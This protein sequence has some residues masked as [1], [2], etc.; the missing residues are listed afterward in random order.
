MPPLK[1]VMSRDEIPYTTIKELGRG[2]FGKVLEVQ[3]EYGRRFALKF[4]RTKQSNHHHRLKDLEEEIRN[5]QT[6]QNH[7]HFVRVRDAY[8]ANNEVGFI[9][10]PVAD[11][12][13]LESCIETFLDNQVA[14]STLVTVF[15][16]AFGC[17]VSGL[18]FMH[19]NRIRHKDIKPANILIHQGRVLCESKLMILVVPCILTPYC[20][21]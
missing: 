19:E 14:A 11:G 3:D 13:S 17:L 4:I 12:G 9:Y 1:Y 18:V 2:T 5:M 21:L 8:H 20:D 10:E 6:L 16:E 15:E 7:H